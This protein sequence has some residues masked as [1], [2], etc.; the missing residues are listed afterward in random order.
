MKTKKEQIDNTQLLK[1]TGLRIRHYNVNRVGIRPMT[2]AY[3][4]GSSTIEIA[5]SIVHPLDK[6]C[7]KMGTKLAVEAFLAGKVT[8][9][10]KVAHVGKLSAVRHLDYMFG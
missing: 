3:R 2:V 6:F 9:L 1:D 8:R 10:P 7:R 5:T 4:E